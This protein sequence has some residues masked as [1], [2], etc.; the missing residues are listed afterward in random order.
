M[1]HA[2]V[3]NTGADPSLLTH[4]YQQS[5]QS[6][7]LGFCP[8]HIINHIIPVSLHNRVNTLAPLFFLGAAIIHTIIPVILQNHS[9][10][11]QH[12]HT[13][14][15]QITDQSNNQSDPTKLKVRQSSSMH[16]PVQLHT[17]WLHGGVRYDTITL[18]YC[19]HSNSLSICFFFFFIGPCQGRDV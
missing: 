19:V 5:L 12:N 11:P 9:L 16:K 17:C 6:K 2:D 14:L 10:K 3:T 18:L 13:C 1:M 8:V 15:H 7:R 4:E